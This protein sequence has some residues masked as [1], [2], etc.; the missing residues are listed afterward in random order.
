VGSPG[1][2]RCRVTAVNFAGSATQMSTAFAVA[3]PPPPPP[4][5]TASATASTA[6]FSALVQVTCHGVTGQTCAGT[7]SLRSVAPHPGGSVAVGTGTYRVAAGHTVTVQIGLNRSGRRLL[8][9]RLVLPTTLTFG[10][11]TASPRIV[12]FRL[13][14]IHVH[15]QLVVWRIVVGNYTTAFSLILSPLPSAAS[16]HVKCAGRGCPFSGRSIH[17]H[18]TRLSLTRLFGTHRLQPGT[19]VTFTI[20]APGRVGEVLRY[21]LDA[22]P[23]IPKPKILCAVPGSRKPIACRSPAGP[24]RPERGAFVTPPSA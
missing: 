8:A 23:T 2:Y 10:G 9:G 14:R 24:V 4:P 7:M 11:T 18:R 16:V 6:G 3:G 17:A 20:T 12:T 21:A 22:H 1:S 15:H 5:P 13:A 19:T